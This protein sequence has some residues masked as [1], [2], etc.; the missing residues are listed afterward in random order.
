MRN[1]TK[2]RNQ[3]YHVPYKNIIK[4]RESNEINKEYEN[5]VIFLHF[6]NVI[7]MLLQPHAHCTILYVYNVSV[8]LHYNLR[9][10]NISY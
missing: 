7:N 5:S 2:L 3:L 10:Y 1:L 4:A 6:R 8:T 9:N